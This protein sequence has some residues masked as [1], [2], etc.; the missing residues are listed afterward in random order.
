MEYGGLTPFSPPQFRTHQE[1][2]L[3][4]RGLP[5]LTRLL[6]RKTGTRAVENGV[7]PAVVH[8]HFVPSIDLQS[9]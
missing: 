6:P 9:P 2:R 8:K 5:R 1:A 7:K 4:K 3:S